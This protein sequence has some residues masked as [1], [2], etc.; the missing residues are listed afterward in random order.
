MQFP[1]PTKEKKASEV[2]ELRHYDVDCCS[3][4][5][6]IYGSSNPDPNAKVWFE[7]DDINAQFLWNWMYFRL[8]LVCQQSV[9]LG[10]SHVNCVC[11]PCV[12]SDLIRRQMAGGFDHN[13]GVHKNKYIE[14]WT[15]RREIT[16]Q[17]FSVNSSNIISIIL[18]TVVFPVG[19][20]IG[21]KEE[22]RYKGGRRY[23]FVFDN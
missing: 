15:G 16:E 5:S 22:L 20:Y 7:S 17:A 23:N 9:I 3:N 1:R 18:F 10:I 6:S 21:T 2:S 12:R 8:S 19:V 4:A 14:E 13:M 11:S